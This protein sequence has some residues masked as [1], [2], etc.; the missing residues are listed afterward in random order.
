MCW[1]QNS[2]AEGFAM[3]SLITFFR[4]DPRADSLVF[5]ILFCA[6]FLVSFSA[7]IVHADDSTASRIIT[8]PFVPN[9]APDQLKYFCDDGG[10]TGQ[11]YLEYL[12]CAHYDSNHWY[13]T[14]TAEERQACFRTWF[15]NYFSKCS[16]NVALPDPGASA[17]TAR[18][19][20]IV[21]G[22]KG[23]GICIDGGCRGI[24]EILFLEC[25]AKIAF[26]R[27]YYDGSGYDYSTPLNACLKA[28]VDTIELCP[29]TAKSG[30]TDGDDPASSKPL[31]PV[32]P[33]IAK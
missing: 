28:Y 29:P 26:P 31:L 4:R 19:N 16:Q 6:L 11:Y 13:R 10:C 33:G 15:D 14:P 20:G 23:G 30:P 7:T 1:R 18:G 2:L 21:S 22:S 25:I 8:Y 24:A 5:R 32:E 17:G 27:G 3:Q 12:R 9:L